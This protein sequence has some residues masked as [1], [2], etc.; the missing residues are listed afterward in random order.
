[1][2]VYDY[3]QSADENSLI[4]FFEKNLSKNYLCSN[5]KQ[6]IW[7][8]QGSPYL[9]VPD[10]GL[11]LLKNS[12]ELH[13]VLGYIPLLLKFGNSCIS[14]AFMSHWFALKESQ[15]K[16]AGA[17]PFLELLRRYPNH[18]VLGLSSHSRRILMRMGYFMK[19]ALP[20]TVWI[21]DHERVARYSK[22]SELNLLRQKKLLNHHSRVVTLGVWNLEKIERCFIRFQENISICV[23]RNKTYLNWRYVQHP[24]FKYECIVAEEDFTGLAIVRVEKIMNSDRSVLRILELL[25]AITHGETSA[26]L[27]NIIHFGYIHECDFMDFFCSNIK[28]LDLLETEGWLCEQLLEQIK[29]PRLFQPIEHRDHDGIVFAMRVENKTT[30]EIDELWNQSYFTKSDGDQD[31]PKDFCASMSIPTAQHQPI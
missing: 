29:L 9:K 4:E 31:R 5:S 6:F 21:L 17:L 16:G 23:I 28:I 12:Q 27:N 20:R 10:S 3:N 26:L 25:P 24:T 11:L 7:Q 8:F 13:A 1:M 19:E 22:L 14:A 2:P 30:I 18:F 15:H